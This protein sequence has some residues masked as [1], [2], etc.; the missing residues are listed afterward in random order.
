MSMFRK[1]T[2][3]TARARVAF[4]GPSGSGKTWTGLQWAT[5]LAEGKPIAFIDTERGSASLYAKHFEFD[6]LEMT[7]PYHP[8]RLI[9]AIKTADREGYGVV[10]IDS[11]SHF[12]SGEGGLLDIVDDVASRSQSKNSFA[13][14][15]EGSPIWKAMIDSILALDA[16]AIITMR[17]KTEYVIEENS[18]GKKEPR[19]VGLAPEARAGVE[20]EFTMVG[21]LEVATHKLTFSKS[22]CDQLADK[23][24]PSGKAGEAAGIFLAWL[25]DGE[26][27]APRNE[28]DALVQRMSGIS[29]RDARLHC[30]TVFVENF[31]RP[32]SL[33]ASK[34]GEAK[35]FVEGYHGPDDEPPDSPPD[36]PRGGGA[37][38]PEAAADAPTAETTTPEAPAYAP[39]DEAPFDQVASARAKR[40]AALTPA[41]F[42]KIA[43][44]RGLKAEADR[45]ALVYF[46]T[47]GR[48]ESAGELTDR[49]LVRLFEVLDDVIGDR[50]QPGYLRKVLDGV[51]EHRKATAS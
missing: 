27:L 30:K 1:A 20:F 9:E 14:W 51:A 3:A 11:I 29:D 31:G 42:H 48:T 10:M 34:L 12:Y 39:E 8:D 35:A 4:E 40:A 28:I 25:N 37:P 32:E 46:V 18:R 7:P 43:A 26:P 13:A 33:V 6:V 47:T 2:R 41:K 23:V 45:R 49:E 17:S 50:S 21:S 24:F 5:T 19:K 44:A 36:G 22:R 38:V 16:H 15:K